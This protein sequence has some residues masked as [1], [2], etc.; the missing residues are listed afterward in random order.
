MGG[1]LSLAPQKEENVITEALIRQC[2]QTGS[3][4]Q[5]PKEGGL[6]ERED[7]DKAQAVTQQQQ[8][9]TISFKDIQHLAFGFRHIVEIDHLHGLVNLKKLQLDNNCLTKIKN[10]DH[11][12]N[13]TW[14]DLSFNSISRLEGLSK[15]TKLTDLSL[16]SNK[17]E[18]IE[19]MQTLQELIVLSVGNNPYK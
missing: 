13:L 1:P 7:A 16:F 11:L 9:Q 2:I 17:L 3:P 19:N 15:L 5:Q 12:V 10:L 14:L 8:Q 6:D 4:K 18:R